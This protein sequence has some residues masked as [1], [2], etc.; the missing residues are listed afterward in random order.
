M[1]DN[2]ESECVVLLDA[3]R[4]L[5]S[6][7]GRITTGI[8]SKDNEPATG[9]PVVSNPL[10]EIAERLE[11]SG[12]FTFSSLEDAR[13]RTLSEVVRRR[14]QPAFRA[15]LLMAYDGRC[16]ISG[17][18]ASEALEAAHIYPYRGDY[19]NHVTNGLLLRA[20][21][22]TLFDLGLLTIDS[23]TMTAR[24]SKSLRMSHYSP[25]HGTALYI[26]HNE[27]QRPNVEALDWHRS[28]NSERCLLSSRR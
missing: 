20:D 25:L 13:E 26:P 22:H 15:A 9:S 12:T 5:T 4:K 24:F 23:A 8:P 11:S 21:L 18:H 3:D 2:V 1:F 7:N 28:V 14:G 17:C 6:W 16:A 19:T 27:D 10:D